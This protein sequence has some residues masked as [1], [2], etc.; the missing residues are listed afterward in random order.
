M[1][2]IDGYAGCGKS[3]TARRVARELNYTFIDS[4]AMY[5]AFTLLLIRRQVDPSERAEVLGLLETAHIRCQYD[6]A[7][8]VNNTYLNG[9]NVTDTLRIPQIN[10][11]VSE[12]AAIAEVRHALVAAQQQLGAQGGVVMDGRDIGTVVFPHAEL[13]VFMK[14]SMDARVV[15]RK[16]EYAQKGGDYPAEEI[17]ANLRHR[18]EL[19]T[20]RKEGPLRK[21][22]DARELDTSYLTIEE[23]VDVVLHWAL[24]KMLIPV[25]KAETS[26]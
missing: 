25:E 19:D 24:E 14:A 8:Q 2:A 26:A 17:E 20:T 7:T 1:I 22:R 11:L 3:T 10:D 9:E 16:L 12:V 5:R 4:G 6:P 18:D 23:Q 21:A 13:K 15:R